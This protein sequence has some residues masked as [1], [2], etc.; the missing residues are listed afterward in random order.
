MVLPYVG[1]VVHPS[2]LCFPSL[3]SIFYEAEHVGNPTKGE[4]G[5]LKELL[6]SRGM[7]GEKACVALDALMQVR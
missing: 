5:E 6:D 4:F 2:S 3:L 1:F 7:D